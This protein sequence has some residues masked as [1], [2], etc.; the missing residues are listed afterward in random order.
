MNKDDCGAPAQTEENGADV[1]ERF[2]ILKS[3]LMRDWWIIPFAGLSAVPGE[4]IPKVPGG[5]LPEVP[6][7][8]LPEVP[9]GALHKVPGGV[10][11]ES[12]TSDKV[13]TVLFEYIYFV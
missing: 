7:R 6:G 13:G 10:P 11:T 12:Y 9:G 1:L 2:G 8:A 3:E 5:V 4:A